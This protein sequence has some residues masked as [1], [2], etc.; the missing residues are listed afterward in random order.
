MKKLALFIGLGFLL[1]TACIVY[2]PTYDEEP[3]PDTGEY[4]ER[5]YPSRMDTSYF[6]D[7]LSGYG[8]WVYYPPYNYIWI[9]R[10]TTYGWRPYTYGRWVYTNYG[11]TWVSQFEWG[12]APLC[13]PFPT[14]FLLISGSL[15]RAGIS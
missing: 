8:S 12:W 3:P 6:Y 15:S 14:P 2:V 1:A 7:Y 9:P 11:W 10:V 4:Y 13:P 5:G